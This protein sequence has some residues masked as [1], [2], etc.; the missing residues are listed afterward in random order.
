MSAEPA[1]L[2]RT[3][4]T[5]PPTT[6]L[7]GREA[8]L[9]LIDSCLASDGVRLVTL[10]GPGGSGKT[11]LALAVAESATRAGVFTL[12]V[13]LTTVASADDVAPAIGRALAL[14]EPGQTI[15]GVAGALAL[16]EPMLLLDNLEHIPGIARVVRGLL[17]ATPGLTMLATSRTPLKLSGEQL[18]PV[19]PLPFDSAG[20]KPSPAVAL[21]VACAR[22]VDPRFALTD[23]NRETVQRIVRRLDGLPLAIELAAARLRVLSP[24]A[25]LARLE[26]RLTVLTGGASDLP[27]RHRTMQATIDWSYRALTPGSKWLLRR[28]AV[29]AGGVPLDAVSTLSEELPV[30]GDGFDELQ[31]LVDHSLLTRVEEVDP[32]RYRMLEPI[33]DV[34]MALLQEHGELSQA[35]NAHMR[36]HVRLAASIPDYPLGRDQLYWLARGDLERENFSLALQW[37]AEHEDADALASLCAPLAR[38]WFFRGA[39]AEGLGWIQRALALLPDEPDGRRANLIGFAGLFM[40]YLSHPDTEA[41]LTEAVEL[42]RQSGSPIVEGVAL[43][44]LGNAKMRRGDL[45]GARLDLV[46]AR[47]TAVKHDLRRGQAM[48]EY[49]LAWL[50]LVQG[51]LAEA[52]RL[53][54]VALAAGRALGDV[55]LTLKALPLLARVALSEGHAGFAR[56]LASEASA[57]AEE[58]GDPINRAIMLELEAEILIEEDDPAAA[59]PVLRRSR[60]LARQ[61]GSRAGIAWTTVSLAIACAGARQIDEAAEL[62]GDEEVFRLGDPDT[63]LFRIGVAALVASAAGNHADAARLLGA[64]DA[65]FQ[66]SEREIIQDRPFNALRRRCEQSQFTRVY[67]AGNEL[68]EEEIDRLIATILAGTRDAGDRREPSQPDHGLTKRELEVL[69]L[70]AS[71]ASNIAVGEALFISPLTAK[72]H[73]ANLLAKIGVQSRGEAAAWARSRGL[74]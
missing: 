30:P 55:Q 4:Q 25:L 6:S 18:V 15:E 12:F 45:P 37:A 50:A 56:R 19:P 24:E 31:E 60:D 62:L 7:V 23:A 5:P 29:F 58:A 17:D 47:D 67:E 73:V 20:V 46:Q 74:A 11:R 43:M 53:G 42:A 44:N 16:R 66:R 71:G 21:F 52:K 1:S 63:R 32:P 69:R 65:A 8:E 54:E 59:I 14:R 41:T 64:C 22:L 35:R 3:V 28:L 49:E 2:F 27:D 9:E 68:R 39:F 61:A 70:V 13:D 38:L 40:S 48:A 34:A 72:T 57:T 33:R 51:D 10:T 26:Q 36:W